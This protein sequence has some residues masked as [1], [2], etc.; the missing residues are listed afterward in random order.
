MT[1]STNVLQAGNPPHKSSHGGPGRLQEAVERPYRV[2]LA[3]D[4][5]TITRSTCRLLEKDGMECVCVSGAAA[6]LDRLREDDF[7]VLVAD[8]KM[9][10]N[11]DMQLL[12]TKNGDFPDVPVIIITGYPSLQ[13]AVKSLKYQ[14][15]DYITKP[16]DMVYLLRRIREAAEQRR[17]R[18]ALRESQE[19]FRIV[20]DFTYDWEYWVAPDGNLVYVS[21]SCE[22]ITGYERGEFMRDP[23]LLARIVHP[24][25]REILERHLREESDS[26]QPTPVDFRIL[27][28]SGEERW[29]SHACQPVYGPDGCWIG[30][31]ASNR[32]I[33]DRKRAEEE[34]RHL[35]KQM[36]L[37]QKLESLGVMASGIAHDFNNLLYA[38]QGNLELAAMDIPEGTQARHCV[39]E[40]NEA[41]R[42]ATD[43]SDQM[44]AYSGR[45]NFVTEKI[46]LPELIRGTAH[47]LAASAS[48]NVTIEYRLVDDPP[49]IEGD[50]AQ[51][52]QVVMNLV[53]NASEAIGAESGFIKVDVNLMDASQEYLAG[54]YIDDQ[55]PAG[56]YV[57]LDVTDTGCGMDTE[58]VAKAFDPFFTTKFQGRGLGLS[59]ALG[60]VR[61]H[62]G[63]IEAAS[64][65]GQG[66]TFSVLFPAL[67]RPATQ[68]SEDDV[69][70]AK[71][72]R[73]SATILLVDDN[74]L[75]RKMLKI[76]LE[77]MGLT[78]LTAADG[79][80]ALEVFREKMDEIAC[81]LL[82]LTMPR[83]GGEEAF[84]EL[85][86]L[87]DDVPVIL[88]SGYSEDEVAKRFIGRGLAGFLKKPCT[89]ADLMAKL[90]EVL[91]K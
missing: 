10:G 46:D 58:V 73:G 62:R 28:H 36:Q 60:I 18:I 38:V 11:E 44:L 86:R 26:H 12:E 16:I 37:S 22:R 90:W 9:P 56:R 76:R 15:F 68:P 14:V 6:A 17:L 69:E 77:N 27:H 21:P 79:Y 84:R 70:Q 34:R 42:R 72:W 82:D 40:A 29:I 78:V 65:R 87:R 67:D 53:M 59:A 61:G 20:A 33:S 63:A 83:M 88:S 89:A 31:R 25:D 7:D 41:V 1:E 4:E 23:D 43:L 8:Y 85:R 57:R 80:E 47:L 39:E 30:Q 64:E 50:P 2:L 55:L 91:G 71:E 75:L 32:D 51:L 52:R 13:S 66:T 35:E 81:V 48:R 45:G 3:D 49:A 24:E 19:Q 54:T 74:E 5:E